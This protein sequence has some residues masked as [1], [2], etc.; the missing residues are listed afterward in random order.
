MARSSIV[1]NVKLDV[2]RSCSREEKREVLGTFWRAKGADSPRAERAAEQ[3]GAY[4]IIYVGAIAL[5]LLV[6]I[7][8]GFDHAHVVGWLALG[9]EVFVLWCLWWAVVRYRALRTPGS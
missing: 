7:I 3:Y 5:E 2:Y 9:A 8:A 4:A 1:N 6:V